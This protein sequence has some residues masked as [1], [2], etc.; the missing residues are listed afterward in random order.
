MKRPG[1]FMEQS[2]VFMERSGVFRLE[3]IDG[4]SSERSSP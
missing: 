1:V 3:G 4:G 2:G